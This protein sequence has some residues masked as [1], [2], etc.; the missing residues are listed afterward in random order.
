M[1]GSNQPLSAVWLRGP[2]VTWRDYGKWRDTPDSF[3]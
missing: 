3:L 2:C 1:E